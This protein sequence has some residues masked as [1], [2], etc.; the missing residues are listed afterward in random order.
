MIRVDYDFRD[1]VGG[2]SSR[3]STKVRTPVNWAI[4]GNPARSGSRYPRLNQEVWRSWFLFE[5]VTFSFMRNA[6]LIRSLWTRG[7]STGAGTI[8]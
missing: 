2:E 8:R 3:T 4:P 6:L 7:Y 5:S 1:M